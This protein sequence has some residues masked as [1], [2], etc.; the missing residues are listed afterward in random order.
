M[1]TRRGEI[2][3]RGEGDVHHRSLTLPAAQMHHSATGKP[4]QIVHDL[5][6][7]VDP[8][9]APGGEIEL[10]AMIMGTEESVTSSTGHLV[11]LMQK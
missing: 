2:E 9:V 1:P 4:V 11:E 6:A 3:A 5:D 8:R 7:H 10:C